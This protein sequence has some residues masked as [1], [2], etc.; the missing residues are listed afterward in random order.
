[1]KA[2]LLKLQDSLNLI[3]SLTVW[4][5]LRLWL[6]ILSDQLKRWQTP[7]KPL[8]H[9]EIHPKCFLLFLLCCSL[10]Y[11]C[12][13]P[14]YL[15]TDRGQQPSFKLV[16]YVWHPDKYL[17]HLLTQSMPWHTCVHSAVYVE[18]LLWY[19]SQQSLL[20]NPGTHDLS[21]QNEEIPLILW[22]IDHLHYL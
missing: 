7:A 17:R 1:M 15:G 2:F 22:D 18:L 3:H 4:L 13:P 16:A 8:S 11:T 21:W 12:K 10:W 20:S 14:L 9:D 6:G 19:N 5:A